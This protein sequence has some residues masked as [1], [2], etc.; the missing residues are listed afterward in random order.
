[1][2]EE[3]I[4]Q[5]I[6]SRLFVERSSTGGRVLPSGR[7]TRFCTNSTRFV[8]NSS[9]NLVALPSGPSGAIVVQGGGPE[10]RRAA[11]QG[12]SWAHTYRVML[13][14]NGYRSL[15]DLEKIH[16]N[17]S[18]VTEGPKIHQ[19]HHPKG[20]GTESEAWWIHER[21][22]HC[23]CLYTWTWKKRQWQSESNA[24][25]N[26]KCELC[27]ELVKRLFVL[28]SEKMLTERKNWVEKF[29]LVKVKWPDFVFIRNLVTKVR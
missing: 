5:A 23:P 19:H 22:V 11:L 26:E 1:M 7:L 9:L 15:S 6:D 25:V 29:T 28:L 18:I 12:K 24:V 8:D 4:E 17:L 20:S 14:R 27:K 3:F 21:Y 2:S 13:W 10:A 16:S